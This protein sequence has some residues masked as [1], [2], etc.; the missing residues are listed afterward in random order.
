MDGT[1]LETMGQS[2][3]NSFADAFGQVIALAPN[4]LAT[5]VVLVAGY[6]V[7]RLLDRV[8]CAVA[9][10]TG[11]HKAAERGGLVQS[12]QQVGIRRTVPQIVGQIVFWLTLCV[13]ITAG[14]KILG[15]EAVSVAMQN[16]VAYIPKLL[17]A[18][19]VVVIGLLVAS[20]L[21]GVIATSAD[22]VGLSYAETLANGCYYV[23][24]L[25]TF[26]GAFDQLGIQFGL[27]KEML[28]IAFGALA[29]GFGLAFGLGGR[30]VM[31][32]ILAGYYTRQRLQTGDQ[33]TVCGLSGI[34]R[35]VGP[36]CTVIETMDDGML[37]RH[38]VP[39]TKMLTDAV[40]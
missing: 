38:T 22:R 14:F 32:G 15:L 27:L 28:L 21:R 17:V 9:E 36:V 3:V 12:M 34:V 39:N 37:S 31:G 11:L 8:A 18:T 20:F 40:R 24:A 26:I 2:L 13:F 10:T 29:V 6:V 30:D 35:E 16:I 7:A 5:I 4:V 19:V 23:L 25:M 33:V 1:F